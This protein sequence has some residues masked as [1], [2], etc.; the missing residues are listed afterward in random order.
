MVDDFEFPWRY[1]PQRYKPEQP[2]KRESPEDLLSLRGPGLRRSDLLLELA[3]LVTSLDVISLALAISLTCL[4]RSSSNKYFV[5]GNEEEHR[6]R[7]FLP[8]SGLRNSSLSDA[9]YDALTH[10]ANIPIKAMSRL[11]HLGHASPNRP[12]KLH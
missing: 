5:S 7:K 3:F 8:S 2:R 1:R 11:A 12:T 6:E 9:W 10:S 4:D